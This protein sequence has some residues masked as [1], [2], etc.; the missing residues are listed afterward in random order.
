VVRGV[1]LL[2]PDAFEE[3]ETVTVSAE[4]ALARCRRC[5]RRFRVLPCDVLPSKCYALAVI[6]EQVTRYA[7]GDQSLRGVA[8]GL[9]GERTPGHTTLHGWTE[10][11]GAHALGRPGGEAGG[12]PF[13]RLWAECESRV[14]PVR[15]LREVALEVDERRYRSGPRRERLEAM[16]GVLALAALVAGPPPRDAL[17][18]CRRLALAWSGSCGDSARARSDHST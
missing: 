14:S 2:E 8:W 13:S 17:S 15:E 9:L 7:R 11:L 12:V 3:L 18:A 1:I 10:G 16:A 4:I 5:R 6:G